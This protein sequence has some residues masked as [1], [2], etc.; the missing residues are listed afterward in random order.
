MWG[1][2]DAA[3]STE[4]NSAYRTEGL[5]GERLTDEEFSRTL[6][7]LDRARRL[8]RDITE[9]HRADDASSSSTA[10]P[11]LPEAFARLRGFELHEV[12]H[13]GAPS[14]ATTVTGGWLGADGTFGAGSLRRIKSVE[15]FSFE[16]PFANAERSPDGER[17]SARRGNGGVGGLASR[18]LR[19]PSGARARFRALAHAARTHGLLTTLRAGTG[20]SLV[21]N[22]DDDETVE[23][24]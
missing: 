18:A 22:Q 10:E 12:P 16:A 1:C 3:Q 20:A 15:A 24:D 13:V 21:A 19:T 8:A 14:G 17:F 23:D 2:D 6:R 4:R 9:A 7:D 5:D 11:S